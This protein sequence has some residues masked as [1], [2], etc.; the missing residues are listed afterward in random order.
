MNQ[1][2][3]DY[4]LAAFA[5]DSTLLVNDML[6]E[7]AEFSG[8]RSVAEAMT[9]EGLAGDPSLF[10][11]NLL[12]RVTLLAGL[13]MSAVLEVARERMQIRPGVRETFERY[14][15]AGLKTAIITSGFGM[16]ARD[17]AA[18]LKVDFVRAN[19]LRVVDGRLTGELAPQ[20]WGQVC[21][22]GVKVRML[23]ACMEVVGCSP[24]Q[25]IVVGRGA[26]DLEMLASVGLPVAFNAPKSVEQTFRAVRGESFDSIASIVPTYDEWINSYR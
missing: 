5:M 1:F 6:I 13:P 2:F 16:F 21:D 20:P 3:G 25:T 8:H 7:L 14:R 26:N 11:S 19:E 17:L 10:K 4:K 15:S 22:G 24:L 18:D 23:R 12:N 9:E